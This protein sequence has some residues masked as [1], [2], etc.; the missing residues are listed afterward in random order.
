VTSDAQPTRGVRFLVRRPAYEVAL[1]LDE[2]ASEKCRFALFLSQSLDGEPIEYEAEGGASL[3]AATDISITLD[4]DGALSAVSAG[5]S[6]KAHDF[7][8][9]VAD[10]AVSAAKPVVAPADP[11]APCQ[12]LGQQ[13]PRFQR[14]LDRHRDLAAQ[15]ASARDALEARRRAVT[16]G[17]GTAKLRTIASLAD[18]AGD[19]ETQLAGDRFELREEQFNIAVGEKVVQPRKANATPWVE[20]VLTEEGSP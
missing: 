7:I 8:E 13:D 20:V 9:A 2:T 16:G 5:E 6:D 10:V 19:L 17:T 14:Y 11:E 1:R 15:L 4:S 18:L 3:L 12:R